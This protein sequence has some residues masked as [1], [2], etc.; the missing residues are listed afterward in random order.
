MKVNTGDELRQQRN[1]EKEKTLKQRIH[2]DP[3]CSM[4]KAFYDHIVMNEHSH[5]YVL[6]PFHSLFQEHKKELWSTGNA[7]N[8]LS[9][10]NHSYLYQCVSKAA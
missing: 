3:L 10:Y 8:C 7:L 4:V 6:A 2:N 9:G 1:S 5:V